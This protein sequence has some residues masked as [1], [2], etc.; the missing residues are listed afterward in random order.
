MTGGMKDFA[1]LLET[2]VLTPSRNAK[3]AAMAAYFR[4]TPDPD[5]GIALAAITR[6]LSLANLKAGALRQL[7]M[8]RVDPD[9]FLMSY[10]Y[11]GDMA[12]TISLIWPAPDG[13]ADGELVQQHQ[14]PSGRRRRRG[15]RGQRRPSCSR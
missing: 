8:D 4:A 10:D 3:I 11:V 12:E 9:L 5:R 1:A 15:G 6:D 14:R 13:D 7:T 2:L